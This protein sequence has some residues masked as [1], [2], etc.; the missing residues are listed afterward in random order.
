MARKIDYAALYSLRKDGR[1][2]KRLPN[3]KYIYD[4][5]PYQLWLK[6]Q[7][8]LNPTVPT[9]RV[10]AEAWQETAWDR[11][12]AGTRACYDAP[13]KRAIAEHGDRTATEV[14][15]EEIYRDLLKMAARG[16]SAKTI[17]MQRTVYKLI[18]QNAMISNEFGW[19]IRENPAAVVPLPK[20]LKRPEKRQAPEDDVIRVIHENAGG[21]LAGRLA[22]LMICT[23]F[24]RGEALALTWN[25][26]DFTNGTISCNKSLS[27]RDGRKTIT[28]PKT[29]AGYRSVPLLP[30]LA[31]VLIRPKGAKKSDPIFPAVNGGYLSEA[32]YRRHWSKYCR[33]VLGADL[34]AHV[35]RHG[36]ATM[37]YEAG[38]DEYTAQSLLG[39]ADISTTMAVY[40]HLRKE[41]RQKSV[42]K[43]NQHMESVFQK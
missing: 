14:T 2:Q 43:L 26:V 32:S 34:T 8:A 12:S 30:A 35:L 15:A 20:G 33:E 40:T 25:D 3:G 13:L 36:Y 19:A 5:D 11:I 41:Q 6:E 21:S 9:F 31:N 39:H 4:R 10:I 18:F 22:F 17:K 28:A 29:E 1:Y 7:E 16:Y 23:G 24:R 37:L 38:V 27:F 42:D